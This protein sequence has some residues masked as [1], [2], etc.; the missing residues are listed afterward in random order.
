MDSSGVSPVPQV[1]R[2]LPKASSSK[3]VPVLWD[4]RA[5]RNVLINGMVE[6][7]RYKGSMLRVVLCGLNGGM[8]YVS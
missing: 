8:T 4:S 6:L 2:A 1:V 7:R 3:Q 5:N